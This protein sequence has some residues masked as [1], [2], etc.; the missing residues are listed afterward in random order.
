VG[1]KRAGKVQGA[2]GRVVRNSQGW[3]RQSSCRVR[4]QAGRIRI[5]GPR[6]TIHQGTDCRSGHSLNTPPAIS[7]R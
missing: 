2:G 3:Y 6:E 4:I 5:Q 7:L 1:S